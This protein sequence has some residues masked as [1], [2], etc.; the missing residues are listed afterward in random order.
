MLYG[1]RYFYD[2]MN[3]FSLFFFYGLFPCIASLFF[4]II[5][6]RGQIYLL[7]HVIL[8]T[9]EQAIDTTIL[10]K[11]LFSFESKW[12]LEYNQ[13]TKIKLIEDNSRIPVVC[14]L[15]AVLTVSPNKQ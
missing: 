12:N 8:S 14:I 6:F 1:Q 3:T 10:S 7:R 15:E 11:A 5:Y 13:G 9:Y 4:V 2:V